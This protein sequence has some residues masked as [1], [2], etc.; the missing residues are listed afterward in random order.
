M[1]ASKFE[2]H[3]STLYLRVQVL[4]I[5]IGA[6]IIHGKT[7]LGCTRRFRL[8]D[9]Q[10][11]CM[12]PR[13]TVA[14]ITGKTARVGV[15]FCEST[16]SESKSRSDIESDCSYKYSAPPQGNP[17]LPSVTFKYH[18]NIQRQ[19]ENTYSQDTLGPSQSWLTN[20]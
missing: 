16:A 20:R 10:P 9:N 19:A 4:R 5:S 6:T 12:D 1:I 11:R 8:R 2:Y 14:M 15:V 3:R 18:H 7:T 13:P 17:F